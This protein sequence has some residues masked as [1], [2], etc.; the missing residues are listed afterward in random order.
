MNRKIITVVL[1]FVMVGFALLVMK[2]LIGM[3]Q[4]PE[5][6]INRKLIPYVKVVDVQYQN[7]DVFVEEKGRL[8]SNLEVVISSEVSGRIVASDVPLKV[9]QSFRK[10]EILIQIYDRDTRMVLKARKSKFL[11]QL[12]STLPDIKVDYPN[13]F[14]IW[15]KFFNSIN[16]DEDLPA[17]PK[18]GSPK[19]KIFI[20]SRNILG[21][22]YGIKSEEE[23]L[24]KYNIYAPFDGSFV[25]VN[26]QIGSVASP[27]A[28]L[29][30]IIE[31]RN[32]ELQVPVE[33]RDI[34]WLKV[35]DD[36]HILSDN[37][38]IIA[39]GTLVRKSGFVDPG[40]QSINVFIRL[41]DS[42]SSELY[43]G[44]YFTAR[45]SGKKLYSVMEI[46][47]NAVFRTNRV[48]VVRDNKLQMQEIHI[49]KMNENTLVFNGLKEGE[50]LVVEPLVRATE[51]MSVQIME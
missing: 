46:P 2:Y 38:D 15:M 13:R 3:K 50:K 17:L 44:Q 48:F 26:T 6:D 30:Q 12:A 27:G 36:V 42:G 40:T 47:R 35:G 1:I 41:T 28:K 10:G 14:D 22:F 9:G 31:T 39:K 33:S 49:V 4:A 18:P 20:A 8:I 7:Q 21:E 37:G 51:N 34:R 5:K 16:L 45:F 32:L 25:Q 43:Q 11:N 24:A 23:R 29:A 19:E